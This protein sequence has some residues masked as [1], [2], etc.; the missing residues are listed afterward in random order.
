MLF[1]RLL[2]A[3]MGSNSI[4]LQSWYTHNDTGGNEKLCFEVNLEI[5]YSYFKSP[6]ADSAFPE[7]NRVKHNILHLMRNYQ[8][9]SIW[10]LINRDK[11]AF[12]LYH[13]NAIREIKRWIIHHYGILGVPEKSVHCS[14]EIKE[15]RKSFRHFSHYFTLKTIYMD[16]FWKSGNR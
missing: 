1:R 10:V 15:L 12:F 11:M 6:Y 8:R 2:L 3:N 9:Y 16:Q 14:H 5:F 13:S 7:R 4:L